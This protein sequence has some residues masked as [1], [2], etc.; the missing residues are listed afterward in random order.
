MNGHHVPIRQILLRQIPEEI[1]PQKCVSIITEKVRVTERN[2]KD[3][4][5]LLINMLW[6]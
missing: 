4:V 5:L 6:V 2:E 3:L 1:R